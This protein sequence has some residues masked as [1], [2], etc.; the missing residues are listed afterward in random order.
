VYLCEHDV[1]RA[2]EQEIGV[3]DWRQLRGI[4]ER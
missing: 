2:V 4:A 3:A 1:R